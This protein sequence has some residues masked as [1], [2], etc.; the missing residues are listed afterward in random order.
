MANI[1]IVGSGSWGTAI[2]INL[3]SSGN[4]VRLWSRNPDF[5]EVLRS[6]RKNKKY[7]PGVVIPEKRILYKRYFRMLG[8]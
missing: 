1:F 6:T 2:A 3:A 8:I 5:T 7:L 4:T